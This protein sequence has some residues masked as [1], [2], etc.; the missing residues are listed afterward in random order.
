MVKFIAENVVSAQPSQYYTNTAL[1]EV[2]LFWDKGVSLMVD[3]GIAACLVSST[4]LEAS[5]I[6]SQNPY[7][8]NTFITFWEKVVKCRAI[9]MMEAGTF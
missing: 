5:D 6:H 9:I 3:C 8:K 1:L 7:F 2:P 4:T